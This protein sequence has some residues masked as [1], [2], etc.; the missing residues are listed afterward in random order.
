MLFRSCCL[1]SEGRCAKSERNYVGDGSQGGREQGVCNQVNLVMVGHGQVRDR[2]L[3]GGGYDVAELYVIVGGDRSPRTR[4]PPSCP[5]YKTTFHS[6]PPIFFFCFSTI[7]QFFI[8]LLFMNSNF[9]SK[10]LCFFFP[11][12]YIFKGFRLFF[13]RLYPLITK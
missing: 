13:D 9:D 2:S 12:Y 11:F 3:K 6:Y 5:N 4:T 10:Q 8:T 1:G 7:Y